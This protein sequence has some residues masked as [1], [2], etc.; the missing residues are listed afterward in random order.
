M[1]TIRNFSFHLFDGF[2]VIFGY[3]LV[4][5]QPCEQL[6]EPDV[7]PFAQCIGQFHHVFDLS[8]GV[9]VVAEFQLFGTQESV[10]A[11]QLNIQAFRR[12]VPLH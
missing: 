6:D 8:A 3:G 9:R 2:R 12:H 4:V 5:Y 1:R 11:E 10:N 7:F